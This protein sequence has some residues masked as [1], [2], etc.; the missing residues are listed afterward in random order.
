MRSAMNRC[1]VGFFDHTGS[2]RILTL[3]DWPTATLNTNPC[4]AVRLSDPGPLFRCESKARPVVADAAL[5]E[6]K[7]VSR[8]AWTVLTSRRMSLGGAAHIRLAS[9]FFR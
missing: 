6:L 1:P 5:I 3:T 7:P 2:V 8:R 4:R 9:E